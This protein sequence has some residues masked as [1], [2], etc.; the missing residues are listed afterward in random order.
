MIFKR[1]TKR[2]PS[3][4]IFL[5]T[6]KCGNQFIRSVF[7]KDPTFYEFQSAD[8]KGEMPGP[9]I[10]SI[11]GF[12][13][14]FVNIR[15]RNFDTIS[16]LKLMNHIDTE[17]SRFFILT[18]HP[19]SLFRSALKYHLLGKEK[20]AVKNKY[21]YLDNNSLHKT[22]IKT[23]NYDDKLI[24]CMIHFGLHWR[25]INRWLENYN[26]LNSLKLNVNLIKTE[27]LFSNNSPK[28]F[29]D[30]ALKINHD[31]YSFSSDRLMHSSPAFMKKLPKHSTGE[32]RNSFFDGYGDLAKN[33]Y[34]DYFFCL[35]KVFYPSNKN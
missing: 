20:W 31:Y 24:L 23:K 34:K 33:F 15:C 11:K 7:K 32:F 10:N 8:F 35:E 5:L 22:L 17:K 19:A 28:F 4:N 21:F 1:I 30:I 12:S 14:N 6:H 16:L 2:K 27:D 9:Y 13:E 26:L 18:R 3:A 29:E 25:L